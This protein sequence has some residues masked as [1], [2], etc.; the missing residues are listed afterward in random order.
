MAANDETS[1]AFSLL[2]PGLQRWLWKKGWKELRPIQERAIK[3]ILDGKCDV[4]LAAPTA[5]GKTEAAFL[6]IVT[7]LASSDV[8]RLCVCIS[9]LKALI[10]DQHARLEELCGAANVNVTRWHGDVSQSHKTKAG[11]SPS[12]VLLITPESLEA[13]LVRRGLQARSFF[14]H[15]TYVVVDELHAFVGTERGKQ[16]QSLLYRLELIKRETVPRVALS[17]TL[18]D[19]RVAAEFLRPGSG[20]ETIRIEEGGHGRELKILQKGYRR[21]A[22]VPGTDTAQEQEVG[23]L[24][25]VGQ[26]LFKILRGSHNLVFANSRAKVESVADILRRLCDQQHVPNEFLPHHGSLSKE[27]REHAEQTLKQRARPATL[28]ATTTLEMGID[29][30]SVRSIAQIGN[31][32]SVA[33]MRQRMGRSGREEG[34]PAILRTY[35]TEVDGTDLSPQDALRAQTVQSIAMVQ[36][37]LDG[38][39]E[40][41]DA[42]PLH[43]STL[44][45]QLLAIV[46]QHGGVRA[47]EAWSVLCEH[48]AFRLDHKTHFISLLRELGKHDLLTQTGD[49]LLVLGLRGEQIVDHYQFYAAFFSPDEFELLH[50]GKS[51]GTIPVT[52]PLTSDS[53]LIFT[54]RRWQVIEVDTDSKKIS[55][56]PSPGGRPPTFDGGGAPVHDHIRQQMKAVYLSTGV[57]RF[58]D[59]TAQKLLA[60]GRERFRALGLSRRSFVEQ[61][62]STWFFPWCGDRVLATLVLLLESAGVDVLNEGIALQTNCSERILRRKLHDVFSGSLVAAEHL[63]ER[64]RN[65]FIGKYDQYLPLELQNLNFASAALD[66]EGARGVLELLVETGELSVPSA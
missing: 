53:H 11:D 15:L 34:E 41:P 3:P 66:V 42:R 16:L 9:P 2:H 1:Q 32:P 50:E 8:P 49:G 30:G 26:H 7:R 51:L 55:V 22:L 44:V 47:A 29:V 28:V 27:F 13:Q 4:I 59:A 63:A 14:G 24:V 37:M 10:N 64:V 21:R 45:Q 48:G 43:L 58:A 52:Y 20:V 60:E 33:S 17:A 36:L 23:D 61:G 25:D 40:P 57:P 35:I 5:G 38:W 18:G 6:P 46:A 65:K 19:I 54:G 62:K 56:R 39:N 12:G 31:P